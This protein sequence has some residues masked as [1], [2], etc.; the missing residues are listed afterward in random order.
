MWC[1]ELE[2]VSLGIIAVRDALSNPFDKGVKLHVLDNI[3]PAY[4]AALLADLPFG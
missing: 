3:D 2:E 4:T 1:L